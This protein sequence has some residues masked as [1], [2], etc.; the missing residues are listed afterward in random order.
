M[1]QYRRSMRAERKSIL[2]LKKIFSACL[3][4]TLFTVS[5][6]ASAMDCAF[7]NR[8]PVGPARLPGFETPKGT[9]NWFSSVILD[10]SQYFEI[11][12]TRGAF[13]PFYFLII[14][15]EHLLRAAD[16]TPEMMSDLMMLK[17]KIERFYTEVLQTPFVVFEHGPRAD[18]ERSGENCSVDGGGGCVDHLHLH[19][20]PFAGDLESTLEEVQPDR[21]EV[22]VKLESLDEMTGSQFFFK[23]Y[24]F[25]QNPTGQMTMRVVKNPIRSQLFRLLI[26]NEMGIEDEFNWRE[27]TDR[28]DF[29]ANGA[30][31]VVAYMSWKSSGPAAARELIK[32]KNWAERVSGTPKLLGSWSC[33]QTLGVKSAR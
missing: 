7:C 32:G 1:L 9:S 3:S 11:K 10:E 30:H 17:N 24:I 15:K 31:S 27:F 13:V 20:L 26:A 4:L 18:G 21:F 5:F 16:L 2:S 22:A 8:Q 28:G 6:S 19:I 25:Y 14:S 29:W 33:D 23:P 12:V